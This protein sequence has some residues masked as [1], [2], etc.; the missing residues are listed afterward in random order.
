MNLA[1]YK[2]LAYNNKMT[3]NIDL[4]AKVTLKSGLTISLQDLKRLRLM[5]KTILLHVHNGTCIVS[6]KSTVLRLVE[7]TAKTIS[8]AKP[9]EAILEITADNVWAT[10]IKKFV[11]KKILILFEKLS[12]FK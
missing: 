12:Q 6:K 11:S 9:Y 1:F 4:E 3:K 10:E 5:N 2:I 8:V 7:K